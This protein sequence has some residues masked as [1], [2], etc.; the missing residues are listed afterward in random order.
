MV[1][2]NYNSVNGRE[3]SSRV[4]DSWQQVTLDYK[5]NLLTQFTFLLK[6]VR[7]KQYLFSS[8]GNLS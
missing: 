7:R 5:Q 6:V 3:M 1:A 4:C 8:S 2:H